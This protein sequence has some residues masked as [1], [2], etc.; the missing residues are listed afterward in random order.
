MLLKIVL[1]YVLYWKQTLDKSMY[2]CSLV[3]AYISLHQSKSIFSQRRFL[4]DFFFQRLLYLLS[5]LCIHHK[6]CFKN[7]KSETRV[8]VIH[9]TWILFLC[10][11]LKKG[12]STNLWQTNLSCFCL[13]QEYLNLSIF[14]F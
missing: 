1:V 12:L 8:L 9:E 10:H 3:L 4:S 6:Y 2:I 11:L 14:D 5:L 13:L 7:I